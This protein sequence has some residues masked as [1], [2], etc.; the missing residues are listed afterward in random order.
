MTLDCEVFRFVPR[1]IYY[2]NQGC[3]HAASNPGDAPRIHLVWDQLLT[4]DAF[5]LMFGGAPV[6]HGLLRIPNE[7][8]PVRT[9]AR[10]PMPHYARLAPCVTPW[11]ADRLAL[12]PVQ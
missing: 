5:A 1:T 11:E 9:L 3:V 2:F 12:S 10:V 4:P 7:A 8:R 6:P